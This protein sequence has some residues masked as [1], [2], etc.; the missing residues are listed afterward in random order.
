MFQENFV[1][2]DRHV[3]ADVLSAVPEARIAAE[4]ISSLAN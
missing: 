2:L 4:Q 1:K 3:D